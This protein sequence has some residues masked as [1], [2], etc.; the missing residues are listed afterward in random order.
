MPSVVFGPVEDWAFVRFALVCSCVDIG[1]SPSF[2][3]VDCRLY[4]TLF[5]CAS[6]RQAIGMSGGERARPLAPFGWAAVFG[7]PRV[8]A[9]TSCFLA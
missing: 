3:I 2:S 6:D 5:I 7:R 9:R 4:I 8:V 1:S